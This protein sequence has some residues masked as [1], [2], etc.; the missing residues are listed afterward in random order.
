MGGVKTVVPLQKREWLRLFRKLKGYT[1]HGFASECGLCHV[2]YIPVEC[3]LTK[4]TRYCSLKTIR[5]VADKL[6]VNTELFYYRCDEDGRL[7]DKSSIKDIIDLFSAN[8]FRRVICTEDV[9]RSIFSDELAVHIMQSNLI[10]EC[11]E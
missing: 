7:V 1:L 10:D 3:G 8:G 2:T 9:I 6:G 11:F 5:I 4:S